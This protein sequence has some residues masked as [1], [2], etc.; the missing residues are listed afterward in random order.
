M[1]ILGMMGF[2]DTA[3]ENTVIGFGATGRFALGRDGIGQCYWNS[4]SGTF[5]WTPGLN[6]SAVNTIYFNFAV[7]P[8]TLGAAVGSVLLVDI[9]SGIGTTLGAGAAS[10]TFKIGST[11][12]K[13]IFTAGAWTFMEFT[14]VPGS[15]SYTVSLKANGRPVLTDINVPLA[16]G[17]NMLYQT[18]QFNVNSQHYYDDMVVTDNTG[19]APYNNSLGDCF[20]RTF[21]PTGNGSSSQFTNSAGTSVDNYSYIDEVNS[22]GADYVGASVAGLRDLYQANGGAKPIPND[23]LVKATQGLVYAAKSDSGTPPN[24]SFSSQGAAGGIRDD[25]TLLT[26]STSYLS[27]VTDIHTVDPDG[28]PL[29]PAAVNNMSIGVVTS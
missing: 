1:A 6:N 18:F 2:D 7:N 16:N 5:K 14:I 10:G 28:N 8:T 24:L 26:L 15:N 20:I 12:S 17:A 22:S 29:T 9:I 3:L 25:V 21:L 19:V 27:Q 23:Y 13:P 4:G 11:V